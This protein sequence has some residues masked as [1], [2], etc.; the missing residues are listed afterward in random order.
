MLIKSLIQNGHI[1]TNNGISFFKTGDYFKIIVAASRAKGGDIY[2]DKQILELVEKNNFEKTSNKMIAMLHEKKIDKLI[3]LLQTNH[4]CSLTISTSQFN[5]LKDTK[6]RYSN[7]KPIKLPP[8]TEEENN[9][10]VLILELEAEA[11]TLELE[12]LAA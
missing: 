11:L 6:Q 3:E 1:A 2:L 7:R 4:S 9:D 12:L 10:D 8:D 5:Q